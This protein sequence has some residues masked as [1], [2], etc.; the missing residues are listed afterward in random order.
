[1]F[2]IFVDQQQ[3]QQQE[4]WTIRFF[5][6]ICEFV[7]ISV[8]KERDDTKC[9]RLNVVSALVLWHTW[10]KAEC[11]V[12]IRRH[13]YCVRA[14]P[15]SHQAYTLYTVYIICVRRS[16]SLYRIAC[17]VFSSQHSAS[18]P[19]RFSKDFFV[20]SSFLTVYQTAPRSCWYSCSSDANRNFS[21]YSR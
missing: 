21:I 16:H 20:R 8:G 4:P 7:C 2:V 12:N 1:M 19:I 18:M 11:M 9:A 3:Q 6:E 13:S 14:R 17:F 5:F 10:P 15:L